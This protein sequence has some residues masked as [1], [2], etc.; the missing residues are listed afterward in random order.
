MSPRQQE[1]VLLESRYPFYG[2]DVAL[3][4]HSDIE[5]DRCHHKLDRVMRFAGRLE[6]CVPCVQILCYHAREVR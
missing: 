3:A 2:A 1:H 5:C 6:L 4:M